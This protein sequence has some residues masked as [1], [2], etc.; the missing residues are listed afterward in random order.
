MDEFEL[1]GEI[2]PVIKQVTGS[3]V[4]VLK[5]SRV[6]RGTGKGYVTVT[7]EQTEYGKI[8]K[9]EWEREKSY[10]FHWVNERDFILPLALL[11]ALI[12][13][14][15]RYHNPL[16]FA[17]FLPLAACLILL[18]N[19]GLFKYILTTREKRRLERHNIYFR[20]MTALDHFNN[21]DVMCFDK[22]GVLTTRDLE[23]KNIWGR[24]DLMDTKVR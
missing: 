5:G 7:G 13:S 18:Q 20:D 9:L 6:I 1:T 17:V 12:I 24:M 14:L 16:V 11:P 21:V 19:T 4:T 23:V 22:T 8:S 3:D 2:M 15:I 10:K